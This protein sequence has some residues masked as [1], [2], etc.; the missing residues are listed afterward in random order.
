MPSDVSEAP[1][2]A[3]PGIAPTPP[4][5]MAAAPRFFC[6]VPLA[7]GTLDLPAGVAR[8][9]QVF[10]LQPGAAITLFDG[11]GGEFPAT[12]DQMTRTGVRVLVGARDP[13]EREAAR[14]V[15]LAVGLMASERMDWLVEK[16]T[17][18]GAA[19]LQPLLVE[20]SVVRLSGERAERRAAHWQAVA[21][22]ACEQCGRNRV[23]DVLPL[24]ALIPWIA[25]LGAGGAR[26]VLSLEPGAQT[27]EG[28]FTGAN[29]VIL[30]SGPEGGL[31]A[32]EELAAATAGFRRISLGPRVLRAETA[33]LAAL[34]RLA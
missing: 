18:L 19:T 24:R 8:H 6:P 20:R 27:L 16:A 22:A 34:S 3:A 29:D 32:S 30:L 4:L 5:R 25:G 11:T 17:E 31:T 26:G 21:A 33:P 12:I 1:G 7:A 28:A 10:R 15:H 13:V 23:P 9:V 14:R 2:R